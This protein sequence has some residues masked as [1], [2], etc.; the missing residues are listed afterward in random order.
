[1][2][3]VGVGTW[4]KSL[5][6][7]GAQSSEDVNVGKRK[8]EHLDFLI[9]KKAFRLKQIFFFENIFSKRTISPLCFT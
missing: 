9:K 4:K 7:V 1:M 6:E 5:R 8:N 3:W 2:R